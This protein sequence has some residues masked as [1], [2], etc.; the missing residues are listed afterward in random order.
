MGIPSIW[1]NQ[2]NQ[3]TIDSKLNEPQKQQR[4][5][6]TR[7]LSLIEDLLNNLI[8]DVQNSAYNQDDVKNQN[9]KSDLGSQFD[10]LKNIDDTLYQSLTNG[11]GAW[12]N[13]WN[14][15]QGVLSPRTHLLPIIDNLKKEINLAKDLAENLLAWQCHSYDEFENYKNE[16]HQ[17]YIDL[18]I[19][20]QNYITN[21]NNV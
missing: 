10:T 21:E 8:D 2:F 17:V 11:R 20:R 5:E 16:I 15:T 6:I 18:S 3:P 19:S 7:K 13:T 9:L 4:F 12:A 14:F 1:G